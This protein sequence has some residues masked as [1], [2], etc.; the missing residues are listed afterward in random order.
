MTTPLKTRWTDLFNDEPVDFAN[1]MNAYDNIVDAYSEPHR[2]YH[3]L[4]HLEF[5]FEKLDNILQIYMLDNDV[6]VKAL[7]L[8]TWFHDVIY[9]TDNKDDSHVNEIASAE[10]AIKTL[11]QIGIYDDNLLDTVYHLIIITR[12]HVPDESLPF[13]MLLQQILIDADIS[14]LGASSHLYKKYATEIEH[15]WSHVPFEQYCQGRTK[16]L[17]HMLEKKNI[18]QTEYMKEL[19]EKKAIENITQEISIIDRIMVDDFINSLD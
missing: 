1:V 15:E 12:T 14:I 19:Y 18:F 17:T 13:D 7:Y 11:K 16:F 5:M 3:N 2:A 9:I 10:Y 6:D 8:A 4:S